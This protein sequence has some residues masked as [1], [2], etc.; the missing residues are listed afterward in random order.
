MT[1]T[2]NAHGIGG[3]AVGIGGGELEAEQQRILAG[4]VLIQGVD[5]GEGIGAVA[6]VRERR[7]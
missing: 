3:I 6:G 4:A 1:L 5:Q 2:E 7:P